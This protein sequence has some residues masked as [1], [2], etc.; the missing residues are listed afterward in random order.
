MSLRKYFRKLSGYH[1]KAYCLKA[2]GFTA[3]AWYSCSNMI[4]V[5][6]RNVGTS[7]LYMFVGKTENPKVIVK[8]SLLVSLLRCCA[9][10]VPMAVTG[11]VTWLNLAGYF[12]GDQM[13]GGAANRDRD[14]LLLQVAAKVTVCHYMQNFVVREDYAYHVPQELSVVASLASAIMNIVRTHALSSHGIPLGLL[15]SPFRFSEIA[16]FWSPSFLF[17]TMSVPGWQRKAA[18]AF[19][20]L[21]C[22]FLAAVVGPSTALLLVPYTENNWPA[23][24]T[25]FWLVGTDETLWPDRLSASHVGGENCFNPN[26]TEIMTAP[27]HMS[28]CSWAGYTQIAEGLKNRHFDWQA[29]ITFNDGV[30]KRQFTKH[31]AGADITVGDPFVLGTHVPTARIS[32]LI[33][34]EWVL[35][36]SNASS[37][38]RSG[39]NRNLKNATEGLGTVVVDSWLPV[40]RVTCWLDEGYNISSPG[41]ITDEIPVSGWRETTGQNFL[42]LTMSPKFTMLPEFGDRLDDSHFWSATVELGRTFEDKNIATHWIDI[43]PPTTDNHL[44]AALLVE[45]YSDLDSGGRF[46]APIACS[47]DARWARGSNIGMSLP[48]TDNMVV[49]GSLASTKETGTN[50]GFSPVPGPDWR[51]AELDQ[52]WLDALLPLLGG[53]NSTREM[54][55]TTAASMY[56]S[57]GFDNSTGLVIEWD[58]LCHTL[59]STIGMLIVDGMSRSGL[60]DNG[61]NM[62]RVTDRREWMNWLPSR[63]SDPGSYFDLLLHGKNVVAPPS[64]TNVSTLTRMHW[65]VTVSG[66][67]YKANSTAAYLAIAVMLACTT[68]GACNSAHM[69]ISRRSSEAWDSIEEIIVLSQLSRPSASTRLAN[70]SGGIRAS[71]AYKSKVQILERTGNALGTDEEAVQIF[72]DPPQDPALKLIQANRAYGRGPS[73]RKY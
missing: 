41:T 34:D 43:P 49:F 45:I 13:P 67:A 29:N 17:G 56:T 72:F 22:G 69:L 57:A 21:A 9:H 23:G 28:S 65:D 32:R 15:S 26:E 52:T 35:A 5:F 16:Y 3:S 24:G 63:V 19:P 53:A 64:T 38:K 37:T 12:L 42:N 14:F 10:L 66:L 59:E 39:S 54:G 62:Y 1:L 61:G 8:R 25:E 46:V 71:A 47:I 50:V 20:V 70:T 68:I 7:A 27:L 48:E 31:Q 44:A 36:C 58:T 51:F 2:L 40:N 73:G 11:F 30:I 33:A 55:W 60:A 4:W 18:L 6:L